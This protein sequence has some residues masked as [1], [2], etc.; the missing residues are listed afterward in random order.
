MKDAP[1]YNESQDEFWRHIQPNIRMALELLEKMES[2]T[3]YMEEM[4]SLF[5]SAKDILPKISELSIDEDPSSVGE[6]ARK[7]IF[8]FSVMPFR[9]CIYSLAWLESN[10]IDEI[11]WGSLCYIESENIYNNNNEDDKELFLAS[12]IIYSRIESLVILNVVAKVFSGKTS[13]LK[14]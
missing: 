5:I 9:Q 14:K 3:Y 12:K 4:P 2:W 6:I 1:Y 11:G 7:L 10:S 13:F 8:I